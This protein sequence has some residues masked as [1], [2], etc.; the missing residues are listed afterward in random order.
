MLGLLTP[1]DPAWV[2]TV[3]G[4]LDALLS[5][6]AHCEL[7]AAQSAL[8]L[9]ARFGG[10]APSIVEPLLALAH[11]ETEH[12]EAVHEHI[13]GRGGALGI[14]EADEYVGSLRKACRK[15][16]GGIPPLLDRLLIH[17]LIEAR[18][19]ERF[20]LLSERLE[21]ASLRPFYAELM[22]SEARHYRLFCRLAEELFGPEATRSRLAVLAQREADVVERLPLGPTVHG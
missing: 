13:S 21:P 5:D 9:V 12:F 14:P 7:K 2:D 8:A 4:N 16:H 10:E 17:A 3:E 1:T 22:Q 18:S 6:H 20:R 11:E 15:D 19:C